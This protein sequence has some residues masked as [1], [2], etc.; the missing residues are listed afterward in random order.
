VSESDCK[1][2]FARVINAPTVHPKIVT[3]WMLAVGKLSRATPPEAGGTQGRGERAKESERSYA[4]NCRPPVGDSRPRSLALWDMMMSSLSKA[5]SG[6]GTKK[7]GREDEDDDSD[8]DKIQM[9]EAALPPPSL[10]PSDLT[11]SRRWHVSNDYGYGRYCRGARS[12][13]HHPVGLPLLRALWGGGT[14]GG[15]SDD[16]KDDEFPLIKELFP[17]FFE[18]RPP[19]EEVTATKASPGSPA[20]D[21]GKFDHVFREGH[22]AWDRRPPGGGG[23]AAT[24]EAALARAVANAMKG[25]LLRAHDSTHFPVTTASEEDEPVLDYYME[26]LSHAAILVRRRV[27]RSG[28]DREEDGERDDAGDD[29]V[30]DDG[31]RP[32]LVVEVGLHPHVWWKKF[33]Q[34]LTFLR[35]QKSFS[36]M[37]AALLAVVTVSCAVVEGEARAPPTATA[38][39]LGVFLVTPVLVQYKHNQAVEPRVSLLWHDETGGIADLSR[40]FGR[41]LRATCQLPRYIVVARA[42]LDRS[43]YRCLGPNC[44]L[45]KVNGE[46]VGSDCFYV[47]PSF[48]CGSS[49]TYRSRA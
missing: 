36:N 39:R 45:I 41:V 5:T 24:G 19:G 27:D 9:E 2:E 43:A 48:R 42:M 18:P 47:S 3:Y 34:G 1:P 4:P 32:M 28:S 20:G 33:N 10:P 22:D 40:G 17:G 49:L 16:C 44:C 25:A 6:G 30:D 26:E 35:H 12:V 11:V 46:K 38:A 14:S 29:K 21:N 31:A 13:L 7:R 37:G 8:D 15:R 23:A